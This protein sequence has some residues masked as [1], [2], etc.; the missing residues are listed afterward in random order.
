LTLADYLAL[1]IPAVDQAILGAVDSAEATAGHCRVY[2]LARYQLGWT[3]GEGHRLGAA[4]AQRHGGKKLRPALT[5]LACEAAGGAWSQA[6]PA[7][8]AIEL[9]HNF[10]LVHD[11]VEDGDRLRRH[12]LTV[13]GRWGV[14]LAVNCGSAMQALV[15]RALLNGEWRDPELPLGLI[16]LVTRAILEMTEGQHLDLVFQDRGDISV[17]S[18]FDMTARKT[19]ALLE[20]AMRCGGRI[21]GA[22]A[23][24]EAGLAR[25]GRSFG[26]AFQARDDYLG[27]W[28]EPTTRG[29]AVGADI[30][31]KKKS[32][33]IVYALEHDSAG[34]GLLIQRVMSQDLI[35]DT[36]CLEVI[37]A[38]DQCGARE[39][40]EQAAH[41]RCA[42]G[43][44]SIEA[45][46]P[47]SPARRALLE[48]AD[49]AVL[50]HH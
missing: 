44:A 29:K 37:A 34:A 1:F 18:Y 45:T 46:L 21:A 9:I 7:A 14:P 13:W 26:L 6:L 20:A 43:K 36:D 5:L 22:P 25:F 42:E 33:P 16:N 50:R 28:G 12:R 3:D 24:V 48:I 27:V 35:S 30:L 23:A 41:Q 8:A 2:D 31:R 17:V 49:L 38:L 10:S 4:E 15:Y 19:G 39:F 32:L 11:D 47:D 40:T